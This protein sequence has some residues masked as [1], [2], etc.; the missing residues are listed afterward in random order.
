MVTGYGPNAIVD[1]Y[2]T[3]KSAHINDLVTR[4][5]VNPPKRRARFGVPKRAR[6]LRSNNAYSYQSSRTPS[7]TF[8]PPTY[9]PR[10]RNELDTSNSFKSKNI[11]PPSASASSTSSGS[12]PNINAD[13]QISEKSF[14]STGAI[15]KLKVIS[16]PQSNNGSFV[17]R[18]HYWSDSSDDESD[19][20]NVRFTKSV[21]I[22]KAPRK[23]PE[24]ESIIN[25]NVPMNV[26]INL[27]K[28]MSKYEA[29]IWCRNLPSVY[30]E[31]FSK[32]LDYAEYGYRALIFLCTDLPDIFIC[33]RPNKGD[34]KLFYKPKGL[35]EDYDKDFKT[36]RVYEEEDDDK[37]SEFEFNLDH[38]LSKKFA[39]PDDV[40][41][42]YEEIPRLLLPDDIQ[43]GDFVDV[44][45]GEIYDPSKLWLLFHEYYDA[46]NNLMD[47]IQTFY[48]SNNYYIPEHM[49]V[50]DMY[51]VAVYNSEYHRAIV[52]NTLANN[53]SKV[54]V[55]YLDYGTVGAVDS[56][57]LKFLHRKF[58]N[59]PQQAVRARLCGIR[60]PIEKSHWPLETSNRLLE[61]V[62]M[63]PCVAH[64]YH[65]DFERQILH[66]FL[67]DTSGD[68]DIYLNDA[69]VK[70]GHAVFSNQEQQKITLEPRSTPW[71]KN[72]HLYPTFEEIEMSAVPNASEMCRL[73]KT[74]TPI[75][76]IHP[77][78][79]GQ[80]KADDKVRDEE[81]VKLVT[82]ED[83]F[84]QEG[85]LISFTDYE[86]GYPD[87]TSSV[88]CDK[89][90]TSKEIVSG[91]DEAAN[92][93]TILQP[94]VSKKF[95][96][97]S[98]TTKG[99]YEP[100][101]LNPIKMDQKLCDNLTSFNG[102]TN[103]ISVSDES[104]CT[105]KIQ[106]TP[107]IRPPPGFERLVPSSSFNNSSHFGVDHRNNTY[108]NVTQT[109]NLSSQMANLNLIGLSLQQLLPLASHNMSQPPS[110]VPQHTFMLPQLQPHLIHQVQQSPYVSYPNYI[111]PQ[112]APPQFGYPYGQP[113]NV[114]FYGNSQN[115][116]PQVHCFERVN[117]VYANPE[118]NK[119]ISVIWKKLHGK[120]ELQHKL[121][122]FLTERQHL[123]SYPQLKVP[124]D[125][126]TSVLSRNP[127]S[128]LTDNHNKI[129]YYL[130]SNL[131]DI[132]ILELF[133]VIDSEECLSRGFTQIN[134]NSSVKSENLK[135][136]TSYSTVQ[137]DN[138]V[139]KRHLIIKTDLN[140]F[141]FHIIWYRQ[142]PHVC[143]KE[144]LGFLKLD[145]P[146]EDVRKA[147]LMADEELTI[148]VLPLN[149]NMEIYNS[150]TRYNIKVDKN[151]ILHIIPASSVAK[152][153]AILKPNAGQVQFEE[154]LKKVD[155][156]SDLW[157]SV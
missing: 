5:R 129:I 46:L 79:Y 107:A 123:P 37:P 58:C 110:H 124:Y 148:S 39:Y 154:F 139:K 117:P 147:I 105:E 13:I 71:V 118:R 59:L 84:N 15:P 61:L 36:Q 23:S 135:N 156:N 137:Q 102:K 51:C 70:E 2:V 65:V 150:L 29:G 94:T 90:S 56:N 73:L 28:L 106:T 122:Q 136:K 132:D 125:Y 134:S 145:I 34:H 146:I 128:I 38:L 49:I 4:Q 53:P 141:P 14:S 25:I 62:R 21:T 88:K 120:V 140:Q 114:Q 8:R 153:A 44:V 54:K 48:T 3:Q 20:E 109:T 22:D 157:F 98:L 151:I 47:E 19:K 100:K 63:K 74:G 96:E 55:Y 40:I 26:Q 6:P 72:V 77:Q 57:S 142:E 24:P 43:E 35:P 69:L 99:A 68:E 31:M 10:Q 1:V 126:L 12:P 81:L 9:Y 155:A 17:N 103:T 75:E 16:P 52:V 82:D 7:L 95:Y 113:T 18:N 86:D 41:Q 87:T 97:E 45:V 131:S 33:I 149:S 78:Y 92:G 42:M 32:E 27:N 50:V 143:V 108:V 85:D 112:H 116:I 127:L 83:D 152:I 115:H 119:I 67:A 76:F 121:V 89:N 64:L 101:L 130:V 104:K 91:C 93:R 144:L 60:P 30:K 133:K 66:V 111:P 138:L 80:R 11:L